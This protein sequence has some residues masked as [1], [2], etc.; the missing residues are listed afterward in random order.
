METFSASLAICAGNSPVTG[1]FPEQRLVRRSFGVFFDLRLN[2]RL[3]KLSWGWWFE[4]PSHPLWR[5]RN[6]QRVVILP[7]CLAFPRVLRAET[8]AMCA[9]GDGLAVIHQPLLTVMMAT[10]TLSPKQV[11]GQHKNQHNKYVYR[12][13]QG[14]VKNRHTPMCWNWHLVISDGLSVS[15]TLA[16]PLDLCFSALDPGFFVGHMRSAV[17][18]HQNQHS[19]YVCMHS[20]MF[21]YSSPHCV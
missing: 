1:E 19:K 8:R 14:T 17:P 5:Q 16:P 21:V 7:G 12:Q 18:E 6:V 10:G 4:T 11:S 20:Y 2:K 3:S 9:S 13:T 15:A